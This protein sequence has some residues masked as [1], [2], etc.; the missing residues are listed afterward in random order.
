VNHIH[1]YFLCS[2]QGPEIECNSMGDGP[3]LKIGDLRLHPT[4]DQLEH[5]HDVIG[6]YL[7]GHASAPTAKVCE[8]RPAPAEAAT[9]SEELP[10]GWVLDG[11]GGPILSEKYRLFPS[12]EQPGKWALGERPLQSDR[13]IAY[14]DTKTAAFAFVA[15][16]HQPAGPTIDADDLFVSSMASSF[17]MPRDVPR[18]EGF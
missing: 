7:H 2:E 11:D 10:P 15:S 18:E 17:E 14:F 5:I 4:L 16:R 8:P 3:M 13:T 6:H 9:A 1:N 12:M